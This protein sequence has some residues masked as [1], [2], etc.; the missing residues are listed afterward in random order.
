MCFKKQKKR[1]NSPSK[2]GGKQRKS[3][4]PRSKIGGKRKKKKI[5]RSK[6]G[7]KKKQNIQ[8]GCW[9]RQC[10]NNVQN[11]HKQEKKKK[12]NHDLRHIKL[13]LWLPTKS[14]CP[15]HFRATL[16]KKKTGQEKAKMP[17]AKLPTKHTIPEKVL[18][19]HDC[20]CYL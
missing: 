3:E 1:E 4:N 18:F 13:P 7:R 15:R 19:I 9:T 8:K 12:G 2:I 16:N 17:K 10:L 20:A 11:C 6:I 14:L 5:S